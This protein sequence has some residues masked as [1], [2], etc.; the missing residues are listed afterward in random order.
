[1]L[2]PVD[3]ADFLVAE[4]VGADLARR[5]FD[6]VAAILALLVLLPLML[7]VSLAIL[8]ESGRPVLF[9]QTR[10]GMGGQQFRLLKFRKFAAKSAPG[11]AVTVR[12]DPRMTRV[13]RLLERTKLDELPQ[14]WN[15]LRGD[16]AVV[17]PRPES[18]AFADCFARG[19]YA[20]LDHKPGLFGPCQVIFR[21]EG[22]L[23]REAIEAETY[24]RSVLFP[25]KA[26]IDLDYF[27]RRSFTSDLRWIVLGL[28]AVVGLSSLSCRILPMEAD[29]EGAVFLSRRS[30]A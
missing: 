17:G 3:A 10:L 11:S 22:A 6:I 7:L 21:N 2:H 27:R 19:F 29:I 20:V 16:M 30:R 9:C 23:Y 24:Y 26:R 1:M 28:F 18:L 5:V 14:L 13:G 8:L 12:S 15:I 25:L 4:A